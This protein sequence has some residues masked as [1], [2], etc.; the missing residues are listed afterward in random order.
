[1]AGDVTKQSLLAPNSEGYIDSYSTPSGCLRYEG[2]T[3][4]GFPEQEF[5]FSSNIS[6][7]K[8]RGVINVS[9]FP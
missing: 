7:L 1:M 5:S 9:N 4:T 3:K 8:I 2:I 6:P